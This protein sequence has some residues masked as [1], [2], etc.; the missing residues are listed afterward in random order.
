ML[1]Q[2]ERE[3]NEDKPWANKIIGDNDNTI[4]CFA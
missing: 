1:A 3:Y 4:F 2:E